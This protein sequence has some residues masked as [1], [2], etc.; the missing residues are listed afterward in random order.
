MALDRLQ[1]SRAE[2]ADD[3]V[4]LVA[5]QLAGP[6]GARAIIAPVGEM[7]RCKR[8]PVFDP[9]SL[10]SMIGSESLAQSLAMLWG[11]SPLLAHEGIGPENAIHLT[12]HWLFERQ[13]ARAD[14]LS[15]SCPDAVTVDTVRVVKL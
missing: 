9:M 1:A 11:V 7:G 4:S 10:I 2:T 6:V 12:R 14:V 15:C 13:M 5:C 3:P 8:L